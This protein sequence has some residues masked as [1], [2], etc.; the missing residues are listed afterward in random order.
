MKRNEAIRMREIIEQATASLPDREASEV[1]TLF[2]AAADQDAWWDGHLIEAGNRLRF[3]GHL[4]RANNAT[5]AHRHYAPD[6]SPELWD[7][8]QYRDGYRVITG[9]I[10]AYNPVQDG[11]RVWINDALW[12]NISGAPTAYLPDDYPYGWQRA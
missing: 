7:Q 11:E 3:K 1:P 10:P 12:Q 4:Y 2:P 9:S 6:Q 5:F 8:I